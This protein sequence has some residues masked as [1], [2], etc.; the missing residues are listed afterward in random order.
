MKIYIWEMFAGAPYEDSNSSAT[1]FTSEAEAVQ[2]IRE[3]LNMRRDEY[4]EEN[5][6]P[7]PLIP[8][9][10]GGKDLI[11]WAKDQP[12]YTDEA[13]HWAF[14]IWD[15]NKYSSFAVAGW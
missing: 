8:D 13:H 5:A 4:S 10:L 3:Y 9:D 7:A 1:L 11:Q 6:D 15:T 14:H 12:D 2:D